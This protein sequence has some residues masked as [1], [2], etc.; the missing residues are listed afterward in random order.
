MSRRV[1]LGAVS[2]FIAKQIEAG[3]QIDDDVRVNVTFIAAI[4]ISDNVFPYTTV[5]SFGYKS[6]PLCAAKG[7]LPFLGSKLD[8]GVEK[9]EI[10]APDFYSCASTSTGNWCQILALRLFSARIS[11][12][13]ILASLLW[14][15]DGLDRRQG[16]RQPAREVELYRLSIGLCDDR[17]LLP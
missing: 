1:A 5:S 10:E 9:G 2:T 11:T 12:T 16:F 17:D 13:L 6:L 14:R 7:V 15:D 4:S 8:N 3:V